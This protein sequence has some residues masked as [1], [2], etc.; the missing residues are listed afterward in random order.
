MVQDIDGGEGGEGPPEQKLTVNSDTP[1]IK[2]W[3]GNKE[4][5]EC[6]KEARDQARLTPNIKKYTKSKMWFYSTKVGSYFT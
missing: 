4:E 6:E 1:P 2:I 5:R 3:K